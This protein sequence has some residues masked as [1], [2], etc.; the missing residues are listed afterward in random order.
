MLHPRILAAGLL[1]AGA[2]PSLRRP[3]TAGFRGQLDPLLHS[4][5]QVPCPA[6]E[7]RLPAGSSSHGLRPSS[8]ESPDAIVRRERIRGLAAPA[9]GVE[10][11][12][13]SLRQLGRRE[14]WTSR[15][16]TAAER[17][18]RIVRGARLA[19]SGGVLRLR[20]LLAPPELGELRLDL[21]MRRRTLRATLRAGRPSSSAAI[22]ARWPELKE[23]LARQGFEVGELLLAAE[24]G[25]LE[26][27]GEGEPASLRLQIMDLW[28]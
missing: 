16:S 17:V 9:A 13:C 19:S 1:P 7:A 22:L 25:D 23:A 27:P 20:L 8:A 4:P 15:E 2:A 12:L 21:W 28:I 5:P 24:E 11:A 10:R 18:E 6:R 14:G 3:E 26:E